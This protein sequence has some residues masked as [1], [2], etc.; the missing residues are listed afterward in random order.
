MLRRTTRNY[1]AKEVI[2]TLAIALALAVT[3][4]PAV[5]NM[6]NSH[7]VPECNSPDDNCPVFQP[8]SENP[9]VL[10]EEPP[11]AEGPTD[12]THANERTEAGQLDDYCAQADADQL[13]CD[14]KKGSSPTT[15]QPPTTTEPEPPASECVADG[16]CSSRTDDGE[17]HCTLNGRPIDCSEG[18]E[19]DS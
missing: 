10:T 18:F 11:P 17:G 2:I 4:T 15:A 12:T 9:G 14:L 5:L 8:V 19:E 3:V 16:T 13:V 6:L 1:T 7:K